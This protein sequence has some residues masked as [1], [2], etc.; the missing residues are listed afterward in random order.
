VIGPVLLRAASPR[1]PARPR[2][3]PRG[4]DL[5]RRS[6]GLRPAAAGGRRAILRSARVK[7]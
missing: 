1:V 4:R 2:V 5:R 6:R 7:R 3:Y